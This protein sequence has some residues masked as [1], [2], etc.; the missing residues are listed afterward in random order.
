MSATPNLALLPPPSSQPA[1]PTDKTIASRFGSNLLAKPFIPSVP[2]N[3][4]GAG[5]GSLRIVHCGIGFE[6]AAQSLLPI[7][8]LPMR[9][10]IYARV[11]TT[12][13]DADLQLVELRR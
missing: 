9:I 7:I 6:A 4:H 2:K 1:I 10:A 8:S 12:H 3:L 13:Q 11:S 5:R